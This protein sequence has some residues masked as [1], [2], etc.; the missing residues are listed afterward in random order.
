MST[1]EKLRDVISST[2]KV[3]RDQITLTTTNEDV[4]TWDS[5]GHVNLMIAIEESFGI[6]LEV[7]EFPELTSVDAIL[8]HLGK[9]DFV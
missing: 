5:L 1:F 6:F 7:E 9:H 3:P 8:K 2:L 4:A